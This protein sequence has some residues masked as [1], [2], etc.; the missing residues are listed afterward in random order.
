MTAG[1]AVAVAT[2]DGSAV[3]ADAAIGGAEAGA[4]WGILETFALTR[5][6]VSMLVIMASETP[7]CRR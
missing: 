6:C 3:G 7:C 4:A 2:T 1:G 5:D